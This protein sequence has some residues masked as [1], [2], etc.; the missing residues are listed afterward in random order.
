MKKF[1]CP[2]HLDLKQDF[3][4]FSGD[5]S[6]VLRFLEEMNKFK[7]TKGKHQN[8]LPLTTNIQQKFT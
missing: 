3:S 6:M 4:L 5:D 8:S 2:H 1:C 7:T